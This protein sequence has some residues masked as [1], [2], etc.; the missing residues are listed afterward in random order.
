[1]ALFVSS[2]ILFSFRGSLLVSDLVEATVPRHTHT[3]ELHCQGCINVI[4]P[5][6]RVQRVFPKPLRRTQSDKA[7]FQRPF[8]EQGRADAAR[9]QFAQHKSDHL[10]IVDAFSAW[11]NKVRSCLGGDHRLESFTALAV[12]RSMCLSSGNPAAVTTVVVTVVGFDLLYALNR[13]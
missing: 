9:Q 8:G 11:R 1:M 10:A 2:G 3:P 4:P 7:P 5:T 13:G 12:R 6:L